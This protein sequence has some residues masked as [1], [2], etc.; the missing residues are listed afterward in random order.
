MYDNFYNFYNRSIGSGL[1]NQGGF[2][3]FTPAMLRVNTWWDANNPAGNGVIPTDG[4]QLSSITDLGLN[5]NTVT[6]A[7]GA[8]QILFKRN[9]INGQNV[10]RFSGSQFASCVN[11]ANNNYVGPLTIVAIAM[12]TGTLTPGGGDTR[13]VSKGANLANLDG[14]GYGLFTG[15]KSS[16]TTWNIH[17]YSTTNEEWYLGEYAIQTVVYNSNFSVDFYTNGSFVQNLTAGSGF[18]QATQPLVFGAK[19][20]SGGQAW[21]GDVIACFIFYRALTAAELNLMH[22]YCLARVGLT[23]SFVPSNNTKTTLWLDGNDPNATGLQ[24]VNG[25]ALSTW[26]DK[27]VNGLDHTQT[28]GSQQPIYNNSYTNGLG[29]LTFNGSQY[30]SCAYNALLNGT[31]FTLYAVCKTATSGTQRF[32]FASLINDTTDAGYG[33]HIFQNNTY[34]LDFANSPSSTTALAIA[35]PGTLVLIVGNIG[36]GS[37]NNFI[38]NSTV[39]T[40]STN[41]YV[42]NTSRVSLVGCQKFNSSFLNFFNG[43]ICEIIFCSPRLSAAEDNQMRTYL[44]KKWGN[45]IS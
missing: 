35:D 30:L 11:S 12:P 23:S 44:S 6:Q 19:N 10:F 22:A 4:T 20:V 37:N 2:G 18:T 28:T 31:S 17:D 25:S 34:S 3:S 40:G 14:Y 45:S 43:G 8:N 42:Q 32:V 1:Y 13:I 36:G 16:L 38:L 27:S 9:I 33:F 21:Q 15:G 5:G 26:K 41:T 7:T 29:A 39:V 24:P